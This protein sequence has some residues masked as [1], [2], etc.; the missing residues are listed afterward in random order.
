LSVCYIWR[1]RK[2]RKDVNIILEGS[3]VDDSEIIDLSKARESIHE[4]ETK[5]NKLLED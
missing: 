4:I 5:L 1:T 2:V 3:L